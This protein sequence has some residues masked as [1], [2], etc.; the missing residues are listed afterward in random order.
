M[1]SNPAIGDETELLKTLLRVL[2]TGPIPV[3]RW[4]LPG[5]NHPKL[6]DAGEWLQFNI[7]NSDGAPSRAIDY[8][9]GFTFE[10][11]LY[12]VHVGMRSLTNLYRQR[13]LAQMYK[14]L[15]PSRLSSAGTCLV[16]KE[17]RI[18]YLDLN[19]LGDFASNIRQRSPSANVN[20][21]DMLWPVEIFESR[22]P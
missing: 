7:L 4:Y 21:V 13:E 12:V 5:M 2:E 3:E 6:D 1:P 22:L 10:L 8:K 9:A 17:P 11:I 20:S 19:S 15:F 14:E 16:V 18:M